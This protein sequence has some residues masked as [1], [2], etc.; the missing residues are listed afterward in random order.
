[1]SSPPQVGVLG[2]ILGVNPSCVNPSARRRFRGYLAQ[3]AA[4]L[5]ERYLAG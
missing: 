5:A 1:M 4:L 2:G 3:R